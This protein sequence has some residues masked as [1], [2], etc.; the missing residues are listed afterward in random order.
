MRIIKR[1]TL[2][3]YW[4][5]HPEAEAPLRQWLRVAAVADWA[6]IRDARSVFPHADA[7]VVASGNTVTVFN[8]GGGKYRLVVAIKYRTRTIYIREFMS[9]AEYSTDRWKA[10]N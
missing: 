9:H 7:V 1:S 10:R 3:G 8:V 4:R 5:R 2:A 6:S